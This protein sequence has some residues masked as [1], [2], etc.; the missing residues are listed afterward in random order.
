MCTVFL[1]QICSLESSNHII[2]VTLDNGQQL[3]TR[4]PLYQL[5]QKLD[6]HFLKINRGIV[7]N[8]DH[9]E[10]MGTDDCSL[11]N[12]SRFVLSTRERNT[13]RAA[14]INYQMDRLSSRAD[15]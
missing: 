7:V 11:R 9:I 4:T 12:G 3:R 1:S 2:E 5:E 6:R 10:R 15:I 13:I 8:M 14:Y